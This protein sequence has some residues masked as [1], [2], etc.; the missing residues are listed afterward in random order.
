MPIYE[1]YIVPNGIVR[2]DVAGSHLTSYLETLFA[3][4]L[5][6]FDPL[7]L[8]YKITREKLIDIKEKLCFITVDFEKD[9][10]TANS[11]K[12]F[13][14]PYQLPDGSVTYLFCTVYCYTSI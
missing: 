9:S 4:N 6:G 3:R 13:E 7:T 11:S 1:G 14:T 5:I 10:Q 8:Q 12:E 2:Y